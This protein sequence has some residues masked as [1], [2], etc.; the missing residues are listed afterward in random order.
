M[1]QR[2]VAGNT[3]IRVIVIYAQPVKARY[4]A[5]DAFDV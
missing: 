2:G 5:I 4:K 3:L 1:F